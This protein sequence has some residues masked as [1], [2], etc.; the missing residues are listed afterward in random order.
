MPEPGVKIFAQQAEQL[1][2]RG[3]AAARG[4]QKAVAERLLRQAVRLNPQH[5]QAWLWLSGVLDKPEDIAFCLRAVIGINPANERA[6]RGLTLLQQRLQQPLV[7]T[8]PSLTPLPQ[9]VPADG[10]WSGWRDAQATWRRTV[11]AL[12]LIPIVLIG[13]TLGMRAVINAQPLPKFVTV[14][15]MPTPRPEPTSIPSTPSPTPATTPTT[16]I[17][18][19]VTTYFDSIN[20]ERQVLQAATETYRKTTDGSRTSVERA[21]ATLQLRE[22]VQ[23]SHSQVSA[24]Q[25]PPEIAAT[26]QLYLD[27]LTMEQ[28]ALDLMREFYRSYDLALTNQAALRLQQARTQ[29]ATA[30]AT[31]EAFASQQSITFPPIGAQ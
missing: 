3:V 18:A 11:R 4:G 30:T 2:Q 21:T 14:D 16:T 20:A 6:Q 28:E 19:V 27:G 8:P 24:L 31:W 1:Y 9:A 17:R 22:Q 29:I 13:S 15:D 12:L 26:H 5:E 23:R 7:E 10:W 25:P